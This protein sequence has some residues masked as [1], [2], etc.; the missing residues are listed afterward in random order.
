MTKYTSLR[1]ISELQINIMQFVDWWVKE[2]KVPVPRKEIVKTME[3]TGIKARAVKNALEG[4]LH[5]GYL[6]KAVL[7]ADT[8]LNQT[9]YV[10]LRRV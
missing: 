9:H 2:E 10:Q 6:R 7:G 3:E 5:K 4:L 8:P 1:V